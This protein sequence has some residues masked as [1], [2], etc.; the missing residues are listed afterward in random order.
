VVAILLGAVIAGAIVY[1]VVNKVEQS[2]CVAEAD[3][4]TLAMRANPNAPEPDLNKLTPDDAANVR[5][6][7][8]Y[9]QKL[10]NRA[11]TQERARLSDR[12]YTLAVPTETA[13]AKANGGC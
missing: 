4:V 3:R 12:W 6:L 9:Y 1:F 10:Y 8:S 13:R 7:R 11:G 5:Q 2:A